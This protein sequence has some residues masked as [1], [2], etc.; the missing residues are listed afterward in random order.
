M[1]IAATCD[2]GKYDDPHDPSFTEALVWEEDR[3]A[4]AVVSSS[5]LVYAF[6]NFRFN[7]SFLRNL[8]SAGKASRR[9]GEAML[10]STQSIVND[11][12][13]HLFGDP[14]MYL[15][16]PRGHIQITGI[17]PD[18]LKALS[19]VTISGTVS[20]EDAVGQK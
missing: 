11:Q 5:R 8:F 13:Y 17:S 3:G 14:S 1:W 12:K 10:L 6:D 15:A 16:D 9:L 20:E 2:F 4:I 19:K 7:T 18:T